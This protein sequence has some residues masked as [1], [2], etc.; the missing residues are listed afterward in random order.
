MS[1]RHPGARRTTRSTTD[2]EP[3]DVFVARV[4]NLGKW[5]EANQQVITV[6]VVILVIGVAALVYYGNYRSTLQ[7]QAAQ[8]LEIVHQSIALD[9][10]EGAKTDLI[11]FLERFGGTAYEGEARLLLGELYLRTDDA[12]QALAVLDPLGGRPSQPIEFQGAALLAA[13]YEQEGRWDEAE[14]T[15][16]AIADRSELDFQVQD[17][18]VAAARIRSAR[19]DVQGAIAL[20]ERL[21]SG[22]EENAPE[23]GVYE[24]RIAE[25]RAGLDT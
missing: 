17:A 22:L 24:M 8:Q 12:Q 19:G 9:D 21:V 4:L 7:E 18:L 14:R 2:A 25:L 13:A 15:Y 5:A 3:D 11:T 16:L 6:A 10:A 23:R 20:Y 1:Q